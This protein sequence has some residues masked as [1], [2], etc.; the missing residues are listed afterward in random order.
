MD[1][2]DVDGD[3]LYDGEESYPTTPSATLEEVQ[4][5]GFDSQHTTLYAGNIFVHE[6][7][8]V[9]QITDVAIRV[10]DIESG[11]LM[12]MWEP[13]SFQAMD[14]VCKLMTV[15]SCNRAAQVVIALRGGILLY[16]EVQHIEHNFKVIELG[17]VQLE[18]E[19][20]SIDLNPI[21]IQSPCEISQSLEGMESTTMDADS[22]MEEVERSR[23]PERTLFA[24]VGLWDDKSVRFLSLHDF[25]LRNLLQ[26]SLG[27]DDD[28]SQ[29][30]KPE[31]DRIANNASLRMAR[32]LCLLLH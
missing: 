24:V 25:S 30:T 3:N 14:D 2:V 19:I 20:S 28:D 23:V 6:K 9:I 4:I 26:I 16:L 27:P 31:N 21:H 1:T 15:A 7:S 8:L 12:C 18:R 17:Q 29:L 32:S 10:V 5:S 11:N 13:S 22:N